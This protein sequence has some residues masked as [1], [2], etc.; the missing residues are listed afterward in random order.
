VL[1]PPAA[2]QDVL[3][4]DREERSRL[5]LLLLK[6]YYSRDLLSAGW[7]LREAAREDNLEQQRI[8][9]TSFLQDVV[10]QRCSDLVPSPSF[11]HQPPQ[12]L[13]EAGCPLTEAYWQLT[14]LM[15]NPTLSARRHHIC[16]CGR[17][18]Y[19]HANQKWCRRCDRRTEHSRKRRGIAS[20]KARIAD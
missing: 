1:L 19:G 3:G 16:P 18:F 15:L 6:C 4:R 17:Q 13:M 5:I 8:M 7:T 2:T 11:L 14:Y 20:G 9:L 12:L 10:R